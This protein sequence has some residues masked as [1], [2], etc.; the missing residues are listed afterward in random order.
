MSKVTRFPVRSARLMPMRRVQISK[1]GALMEFLDMAPP[2]EPA[3]R[4]SIAETA[5]AATLMLGR[6]ADELARKGHVAAAAAYRQLEG[7][8]DLLAKRIEAPMLEVDA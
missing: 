8:A 1:L 3:V 5:E 6:L 7:E 2:M 4:L